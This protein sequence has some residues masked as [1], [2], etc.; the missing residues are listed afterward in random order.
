MGLA[1][2]YKNIRL[3]S[4]RMGRGRGKSQG[5]GLRSMKTLTLLLRNKVNKGN[6]H[7]VKQRQKKKKSHGIHL[8]QVESCRRLFKN[9]LHKT[10]IDGFILFKKFFLFCVC[11]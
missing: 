3:I 9:G 10:D 8:S 11:V 2:A 7:G 4:K 1:D 6:I 5:T